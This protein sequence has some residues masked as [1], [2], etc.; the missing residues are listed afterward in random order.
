M[1]KKALLFFMLATT[2]WVFTACKHEEPRENRGRIVGTLNCYDANH[3]GLL[4]GYF[5][6]INGS[7]SSIHYQDAFLAFHIDIPESI[8]VNWGI[9]VITPLS[10]PYDFTYKILTTKD[11]EY[12]FFEAPRQ[13]A[14]GWH[15]FDLSRIQQVIVYPKK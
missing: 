5:V 11:E 15:P 2:F 4:K 14:M 1:T 3:E 13:N 9:Q 7:D 8:S 12:M 6:E 10:I